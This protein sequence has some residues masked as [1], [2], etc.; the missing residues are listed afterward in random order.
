MGEDSGRRRGDAV[1]RGLRRERGLGEEEN[2]P[3]AVRAVLRG[4]VAE[5]FHDLRLR[6]IEHDDGGVSE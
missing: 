3:G 4:T 5:E 2:L 1:V 6:A